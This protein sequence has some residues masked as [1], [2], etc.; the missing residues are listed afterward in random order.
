MGRARADG[1]RGSGT[2]GVGA[3][4]RPPAQELAGGISRRSLLGGGA[5]AAGAALA[6]ATSC[7]QVPAGSAGA[8]GAAAGGSG[9][10]AGST[11]SGG[12]PVG[13]ARPAEA[14]ALFGKDTV[15][16]YGDHQAGI[17]T[18]QQ[19]HGVFV[20]L[21][22]RP[23]LGADKVR[24]MLQMLSDDVAHLVAGE[25][26]LTALEPDIAA[27]P[28]RLTVTFGFGRG[29][30]AAIGKPAAMPPALA[31]L[32]AFATDKLEPAWGQ[33]DLVLQICCEEP[34]TLSYAQR[35]LIRDAEPFA[36]VA[37]VQ[38]GFVNS[39][40]TEPPGTTPRNLMGMRDGTANER[41][42]E[43][44]A[45]VVWCTD[46]AYGWLV[47]GSHLVIRR[48]R[49]DLGLWDD[50]EGEGKEIAFG[51]RIGNGAP[52]TGKTEFDVVDREKKDDKGFYVVDP[53]SHAARAQAR[54][55]DERIIRRAYNYDDGYLPSGTPDAGLIFV[56]YQKDV[57]KAFIPVQQRLAEKDAL[58]IWATHVGSA[59]YAVPPGPKPGG[60]V[61]QTLFEG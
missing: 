32:P 2:T 50:V 25:K 37:W 30:F 5:L 55:A 18:G 53:G 1:S 56:C 4:S 39:L 29:L 14:I 38:A 8:T 6:G 45:A 36:T 16:F 34:V 31:T 17:L 23:G 40:G 48:M 12:G 41:D 3:S 33:T 21:N 52:L 54:T 60:Y 59:S 11:A 57:A 26:P 22:L 47:G 9:S 58:N 46:P 35:R 44:A 10:A 49:I 24:I 51:R 27:N 13:V 20:G 28:A 43:Q 61:G 7:S 42:P 15:P 19:A